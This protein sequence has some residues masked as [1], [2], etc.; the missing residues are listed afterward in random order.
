MSSWKPKAGGRLVRTWVQLQSQNSCPSLLFCCS[1][2]FFFKATQE[3]RVCC[4][5]HFQVTLD[6]CGKS[7]H[8]R[9]ELKQ[10]P[11]RNAAPLAYLPW[12]ALLARFRNRNP[13]SSAQGWQHPEWAEL[14][15][16]DPHSR[17]SLHSQSGGNI[18][19]WGS[20]FSGDSSLCQIGN[21]NQHCSSAQA[22]ITWRGTKHIH[23][24][25]SKWSGNGQGAKC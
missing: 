18:Y 4:I 25:G 14:S 7:G 19:H 22:L 5:V 11:R 3:K 24:T 23:G 2:F 20:L 1:D 8:W 21:T 6:H 16:I 17:K 12:L 9:A 10:R 13:R 15:H